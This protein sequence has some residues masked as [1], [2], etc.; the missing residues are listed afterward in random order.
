LDCDKFK[1][2]ND[3]LGHDMGDE[4]IKEFAKRIRTSLRDKDTVSRIGGDE[5]TIIIP[6][7]LNTL[8]IKD[9][10]KRLLDVMQEP[11]YIKGH[12]IRLTTSIGVATY[13]CPTTNIDGLFKLADENL[14]KSKANGGNSY[15]M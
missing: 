11:M 6:E 5:F 3:T 4:V 9:I 12:E 13:L 8:V 15:T 2:I 10:A 1:S 14:Y 7:A